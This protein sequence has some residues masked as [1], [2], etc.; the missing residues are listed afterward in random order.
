[1]TTL[2]TAPARVLVDQ[3]DPGFDGIW[4]LTYA[5]A[6]AAINLGLAVPLGVAVDLTYAAMDFREAQDELEWAR[7]DLAARCAAVN[8]GQFDPA[9]GEARARLVI[10]Q[11]ATAGLDRAVALA[12]TDLPV[13]D[14]LCLARVMAKLFTGRAKVT[15]CL[16]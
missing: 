11:L 8:L 5:A 1:M 15:G 6:H 3:S 13:P 16:P 12:A 7:P 2:W 14:L 4:T 10:D 9:E